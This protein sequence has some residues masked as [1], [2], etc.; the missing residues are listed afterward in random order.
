[1]C[2]CVCVCE[3]AR[4]LRVSCDLYCAVCACVRAHSHTV[5]DRRQFPDAQSREARAIS[6]D[7]LSVNVRS[8]IEHSQIMCPHARAHTHGYIADEPSRLPR[9]RRRI[10]LCMVLRSGANVVHC[11]NL[12]INALSGCFSMLTL[13][14]YNP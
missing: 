3:R 14:G 12:V 10:R 7:T 13:L 11:W 4:V 2:V 1:M 5:L 6:A 8:H 9:H